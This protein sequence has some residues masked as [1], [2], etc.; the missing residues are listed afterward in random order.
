MPTRE[1]P[2]GDETQVNISGLPVEYRDKM[3]AVSNELTGSRRGRLKRAYTEAIVGLLDEL[4][5]RPKIQLHGSVKGGS[6]LIVWIPSPVAEKLDAYCKN[7]AFKNG[8]FVTAV[9]R[10]LK[11]KG[12][13]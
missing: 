6:R 8:F 4:D 5:K 10:Y 11:S 7:R 1:G 2:E 3:R 13:L 12:Q 9:H